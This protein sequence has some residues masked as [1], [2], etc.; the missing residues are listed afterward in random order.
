MKGI[1]GRLGR[2]WFGAAVLALAFLVLVLAITSGVAR[3]AGAAQPG[4]PLAGESLH[5]SYRLGA[6]HP[7]CRL[8]LTGSIDCWTGDN[9]GKA[10]T[11]IGPYVQVGSG[12]GHSCGLRPDG[13]VDCWG[14]NNY[15]QAEDQTGPFVQIA[16][17]SEFHTCALRANGSVDCWGNNSYGQAE[18]QAGPFV[19]ITAGPYHTCGLKS[20]GSALCWGTES[21]GVN[22]GHPGPFTQISAGYDFNCGLSADG[23]AVCW[24][25]G[26]PSDPAEGPFVQLATGASHVCGLMADGRVDCWG[27]TY[28]H[29]MAADQAGPYI[30]ISAGW[31][32]TCAMSADGSVD[33]WG[34]MG[35]DQPAPLSLPG[36]AVGA[37]DGHSC[38][39]RPNGRID[40]WGNNQFGQATDR[41]GPFVQV[42]VGWYHTCGLKPDGAVDCWGKN[43]AGQAADPAGLFQYVDAGAFHTCGLRPNG[44]V[45][46]WGRNGQ[47]EAE[48]RDGPFVQIAVDNSH[49][50]GLR[51]NGS[52]DCWGY[53]EYGE[54]ADQT[55]PFTQITTGLNH[56]CG[57]KLDG[58]IDCWG[59]DDVGQAQDQAGSFSRVTAGA[60]HTCA[61]DRTDGHALCWGLNGSGQAAD[62]T[63][64]FMQ[65]SAGRH[66]TC[67][68]KSN[69]EAVCWGA[70]GSGESTARPGSFG[71]YVVPESPYVSAGNTHTCGLRPDGRI[72]C[73]GDNQYGKATDQVGPYTMVSAGADHTCGLRVDGSADCW[74]D[75]TWGQAEDQ[76][77]PFVWVGAGGANSCGLKS[78]GS[79]NC[80]GSDYD[81]GA[82]NPVGPFTAL[83]VGLDLFVWG[84]FE[85]HHNCAL[86][87]D[88]GVDCW[89]GQMYVD[90]VGHDGPFRQIEA[91]WL[92]AC[93][94]AYDGGAVCWE[95][96]DG[97]AG[98]AEVSQAGPFIQV[99]T[100]LSHSCGFKPGGSLD[101]WGENESGQASNQTGFFRRIYTGGRHTCGLRFDG[102]VDCWG[103]NEFGQAEDQTGPFGPYVP[104]DYTP[105]V[106]VNDAYTVDQRQTLTVVE[107]GVMGNDTHYEDYP[108]TAWLVTTAAHGNLALSDT[109]GFTYVPTATF[110]GTDTF[111]YK[112]NDG[113]AD[114]NVATVTITVRPVY[115]PPVTIGEMSFVLPRPEDDIYILDSAPTL[116]EYRYNTDGPIQFALDVTRVV[117]RT[118]ANGYLKDV[119]WLIAA[120]IVPPKVTLAIRAYDVDTTYSGT[121]VRPERN[122]IYVNGQYVGDLTGRNDDWKQTF[123][124][125]DVRKIR[126]AVPQC[127]EGG[128]E[129]KPVN[130][131]ECTTAP[132]PGHNEIRVDVD[133]DNSQK[134]WGIGVESVAL[135][136][137]AARPILLVHGRGGSKAGDDPCSVPN[138]GVGCEYWDKDDGEYYFGFRGRLNSA[139]FLTLHMENFMGQGAPADHAKIIKR[140]V[141][142]MRTRYGV[143]RINIVAHSKG[144]LDSRAYISNFT[145]NP[146]NDVETLITLATPQFGSFMAAVSWGV[147]WMGIDDYEYTDAMESLRELKAYQFS[148]DHPAR[149]GVR[150][151][152][153][154]AESGR[155]CYRVK[156]IWF[157]GPV[158]VAVRCAEF[159]QAF[160]L[161][162]WKQRA[163]AALVYDIL[164]K[165]GLYAGGN[166]FMVTERSANL[167][168][169]PGHN[170]SNT[171]LNGPRDL[172]HHSIAAALRRHNDSDMAIVNYIASKLR[173]HAP[174]SPAGPSFT[175]QATPAAPEVATSSLG[176]FSGVVAEGQTRTQTVGI[177]AV[178]SAS[179]V[180][181]WGAGDLYLSLV[182]PT[183]RVISSATTDPKITYEEARTDEQNDTEF[184]PGKYAVFTVIEPPYGEWQAK[185]TAA[186]Q[187]PGDQANWVV[188]VVQD[189]DIT[190]SLTPDATWRPLNGT[191]KLTSKVMIKDAPLAGATVTCTVVRPDGT[192][193]TVALLDDGA[194]NDGAARDG[195]YANA[196]VGSQYGVYSLSAVATGTAHEIPF[197]RTTFSEV[198]FGS[199][200]AQISG[201]FSDRGVD[202]DGDGLYN[203]LQVDVPVQVTT[204]GE[205]A[206]FAE[207]RSTSGGVLA[208][209]NA[210]AELAPGQRKLT[211]NFS[212]EEIWANGG[213]GRFT[214]AELR[215]NDMGADAAP[216]RI[217]FKSAPYTT[218]NYA[219]DQFQHAAAGLTGVTRDYGVDSNGNGKYDE[220]VV[221]VEVYLE[222][223]GAY[224]WSGKLVDGAGLELDS[225]GG[226]LALDAGLQTI[227]FRFDGRN[228]GTSQ[229][230]GP[231]HLVAFDLWGDGAF[232]STDGAATTA[233]YNY[234]LFEG[235]PTR[236][237]LYLPAISR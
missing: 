65:I 112:V 45:D 57:L 167:F 115:D 202:T 183:G 180:L 213:N 191:V 222:V 225:D 46:C 210:T 14:R 219:R 32:H 53:D 93:G 28:M 122:K 73:W 168:N 220:L 230:H 228:I 125:V 186:G 178:T 1:Q 190:L 181:S 169:V 59:N 199:G 68:L 85:Y 96:E 117:G 121:D 5:P 77:G 52:V 10:T 105:P 37:G 201:T 23:H 126:F 19:Q 133:V 166:D 81:S 143:D 207:L 17:G 188:T 185:I 147:S 99:S 92:H 232:L 27:S 174:S 134:V 84:N 189:S 51:P 86:R 15:G 76:A 91:G 82:S 20:D 237:E 34:Q 48:G 200:T 196:F 145:H 223:G 35:F 151:H 206:A 42:S 177:D 18:D 25:D 6:G 127:N 131:S 118:D 128:R 198:Q 215:L 136:F 3:G 69:G 87:P 102:S 161:P 33:C 140:V 49:T 235:A 21:W 62:P 75:S 31:W 119:D 197:L 172:N 149:D 208:Y 155:W 231:Y 74:G 204:A 109:G 61:I 182:D 179:I 78:D 2:G 60:G 165:N 89:E 43:A 227:T 40:C 135:M 83:S 107:P 205:Y 187:L 146:D 47:G 138:V 160:A 218:T 120:G 173:V 95:P 209:A 176:M 70:N 184:L 101:C 94:L 132:I 4:A 90:A 164:L 123:I 141:Q 226:E 116:D 163:T 80:W 26:T 130:M 139:G 159:E 97:L 39:L 110:S 111:T 55:G 137:E 170:S 103:N 234:R 72:D 194:H 154:Y 7:T 13:S 162:D 98:G 12:G 29:N 63:G 38:A 22:Q 67:A 152:A 214:L 108:I 148:M 50:C 216:L 171:T 217:D 11:Q 192:T 56:T 229:R 153:V 64:P 71:V 144:G 175:T 24:G 88:G 58:K 212:G 211:L 236:V 158:P 8:N 156:W 54:T 41:I 224:D 66:H 150:Y 106:A 9:D 203:T 36:E 79:V 44:R 16:L 129:Q 113:Q 195:V 221:Q 100:R 30:Q 124:Q 233:F 142:Q 114:S 193:Q 157:V 104:P